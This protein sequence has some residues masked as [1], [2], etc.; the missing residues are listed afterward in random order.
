M[1]KH[2][3]V[4]HEDEGAA[5]R[6]RVAA[7]LERGAAVR[8]LEPVTIDIP[9]PLRPEVSN[10]LRQQRL[11]ST[12][13]D[14][15]LI[16]S[17]ARALHADPVTIRLSSSSSSGHS[18]K[19]PPEDVTKDP[20]GYLQEFA[21]EAEYEANHP[22]RPGE[23]PYKARPAIKLE[24]PDQW[25]GLPSLPTQSIQ[26]SVATSAA[27]AKSVVTPA[28]PPKAKPEPSS[29]PMTIRARVEYELDENGDPV[30]LTQMKRIRHVQQQKF[31][32]AQ[33]LKQKVSQ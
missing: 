32:H 12:L 16:E 11:A 10:M 4:I 33:Y 3:N 17:V 13:S 19:A 2:Y 1:D 21:R 7:A 28:S 29:S 24:I 18:P 30:R 14:E 25:K 5:E 26:Q 6:A 8:L 22:R 31:Q 27:A 9:P 20:I 23:P 15:E